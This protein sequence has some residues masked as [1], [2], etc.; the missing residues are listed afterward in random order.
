MR[1]LLLVL[2][3]V[4]LIAA[5]AGGGIWLSQKEEPPTAGGTLVDEAA[6]GLLVGRST[7][8]RV[9]WGRL[10]VTVT[11]PLDG[12]ETDDQTASG[13]FLGVQV[14]LRATDDTVPVDRLPDASLEDPVFGVTADGEEWELPAL[15]GWVDGVAI[16]PGARRQ[17]VALPAGAEEV[18]VTMTYDGVTQTIDATTADVTTGDAAPLYDAS[19]AS[20]GAPCGDQLWSTG[21]AAVE[22]AV[23]G[24]FVRSSVSHAYVAGLGWAPEGSRWLVVTVVPGAPSAFEKRRGTYQVSDAET[25]YALGFTEPVEVYAAND[26]LP[27]TVEPD[28]LDPQVVVFEVP[29]DRGTG[30]MD[31]RTGLTGELQGR[32]GTRTAR[33]LV[34]QGAFV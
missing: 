10:Q 6:D 30:Q 19:F 14:E 15:T 22:G 26:L 33:A 3:P 7:D 4:L 16:V 23:S 11:E 27:D 12:I 5:L 31:I 20:P 18:A 2:V 8:V 28:L 24:C 17:Y 9:P 13:S 29:Q 25:S 34:V 21:A 32:G 1:K